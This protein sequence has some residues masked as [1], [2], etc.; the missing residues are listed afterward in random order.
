MPQNPSIKTHLRY[1]S[2]WLLCFLL[3]S[4]LCLADNEQE[5]RQQLK[6]LNKEMQEIKGL[7][8]TFKNQRSQ[9]QQSLAKSEI[10]IG[11]IQNKIANVQKKI[12]RQQADLKKLQK[13]RSNI[14]LA[15]KK[16]KKL[17]EQQILAAFQI[18]QQKKLKMLLNQDQ[19][20]KLSRA[21]KYYDYF[22][23]ART[24]QIN[25]YVATIETLN[26][27]E[28]SIAEKTQSL[29]SAKQVLDTQ[30]K[31][32]T[33]GKK[34]RE[35]SLTKINRSIKNKDQRLQKISAEQKQLKNLIATLE[36]AISNIKIPDDYNAFI[37]LKGK[38]P[39]PLEGKIKNS[40]GSR[41]SESSLRWQGINI[42][43]SAGS[44]VKAIHHGRVVFA[45]W[46][47]GSGLLVIIDHGD[48]YMSLYAHNQSLLIEPGQWIDSG[49]VIATV[50]NSGGQKNA[51]L[52]FEIRHNGEPTD[53]KRWC[54]R[55]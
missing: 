39:W 34:E 36:Q 40:F 27:L 24:E 3:L 4:P 11:S 13:D 16:Q 31:N 5:K 50:G 18:G 19:P 42:G 38:L 14:T 17:I 47:R 28:L 20:E 44:Q 10:A 9:L 15:K 43:A 12:N 35:R 7:L 21:L 1:S 41:R 22:N 51:G 48:G 26:K 33:D 25:D 29:A 6:S 53:P 46:F 55:V 32:L 23:Q 49:D 54:K 30:K 2:I 45:D 8:L 37:N 52:Y